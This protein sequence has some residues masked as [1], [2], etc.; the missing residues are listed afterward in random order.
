[1]RGRIRSWHENDQPII[2]IKTE[3]LL[4]HGQQERKDNVRH[5]GLRDRAVNGG[6]SNAA[7][8]FTIAAVVGLVFVVALVLTLVLR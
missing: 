2:G 4:N 5:A 7:L 6:M 1:M 8:T 3:V